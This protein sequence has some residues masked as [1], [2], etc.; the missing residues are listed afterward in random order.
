M[1]GQRPQSYPIALV[2]CAVLLLLFGLSQVHI[3]RQTISGT[4]HYHIQG[5]MRT[6]SDAGYPA[7]RAEEKAKV[8]QLKSEEEIIKEDSEEIVN[9]DFYSDAYWSTNLEKRSEVQNS[10]LHNSHSKI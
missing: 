7:Q 3:L 2:L 9:P 1:F 5:P 4:Y 8:T 6:T 10:I